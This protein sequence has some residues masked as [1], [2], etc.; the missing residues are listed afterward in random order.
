MEH[1]ERAIN[2]SLV[3]PPIQQ[4]ID[5]VAWQCQWASAF[6]LL[7]LISCDDN[8]EVRCNDDRHNNDNHVVHGD[9][10]WTLPLAWQVLNI[11][12][13]QLSLS[14]QDESQA[15]DWHDSLGYGELTPLS[16]WKVLDRWMHTLSD[17]NQ[18]TANKP[19]LTIVDVGSGSGRLLLA[20]GLYLQRKCM[21]IRNAVVSLIA[22]EIVPQR[23]EEA[24]HNYQHWQEH[25]QYNGVGSSFPMRFVWICDDFLRNTA[26]M[27]QADL[28]FCHAT[29]FG[30]GLWQ[31]LQD[32]CRQQCQPGT[33]FLWITR[34]LD[35]VAT[36]ESMQLEMDW[37]TATAHWQ[38]QP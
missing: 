37:G 24:L 15:V 23:H 35:Y 7:P 6:P 28:I 10:D 30:E 8:Q 21:P 33:R 17:A 32:T 36:T 4:W 34:Y 11:P 22:I 20:A 26:W 1:G 38:V 16:V 2:E 13:S 25:M 14:R 29:H 3:S 19:S 31:Q 18:K 27:K 5:R 12:P 9:D